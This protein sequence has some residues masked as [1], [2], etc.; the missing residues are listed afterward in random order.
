M[1]AL[2]RSRARL[3]ANALSIVRTFETVSVGSSSCNAAVTGLTTVSGWRPRTKSVIVAHGI[4]AVRVEHGRLRRGPHRAFG[5]VADDADDRQV[6]I[7][8]LHP[9]GNG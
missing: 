7:L 1:S 8:R 3:S 2:M 4:A 6:R 5:D 9:D